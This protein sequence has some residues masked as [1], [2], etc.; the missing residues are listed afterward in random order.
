MTI[1]EFEKSSRNFLG[2][3]SEELGWRGRG[4]VCGAF[5]VE[6]TTPVQA[7]RCAVREG[8]TSGFVLLPQKA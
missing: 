5:Q 3:E 7:W 1:T 8:Q 6:G 2:Q 4:G